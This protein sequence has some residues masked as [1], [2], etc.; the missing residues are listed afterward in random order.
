MIDKDAGIIYVST[1]DGKL[2]GLSLEDGEERM[3]PT[4]FTTPFARNWS[5]NLIDGVIYSSARPRLRWSDRPLHGP[6]FERSGAAQG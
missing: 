6:G 1:S 3:P 4:D 5:L 2:R